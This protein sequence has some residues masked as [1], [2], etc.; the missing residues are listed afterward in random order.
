M[1][2]LKSGSKG[3]T[4]RPEQW[5]DGVIDKKTGTRRKA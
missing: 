2:T 1:V 5:S 3:V 4:K